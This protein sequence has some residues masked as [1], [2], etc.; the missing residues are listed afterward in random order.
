MIAQDVQAEDQ[1]GVPGAVGAAVQEP[2]EQ[3]HRRRQ[4]SLS[5]LFCCLTVFQNPDQV[6]PEMFCPS[7]S[8]IVCF[9]PCIVFVI[10]YFLY[11][12]RPIEASTR[13]CTILGGLGRSRVRTRDF[14]LQ[15]VRYHRATSSP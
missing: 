14:C 11:L 2:Q 4:V 10:M 15:Q 13:Y 7:G 1:P 8:E 6:G 3:G 5:E 9:F 12:C